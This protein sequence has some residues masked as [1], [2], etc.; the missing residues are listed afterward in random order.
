MAPWQTKTTYRGDN[1]NTKYIA[2][3]HSMTGETWWQPMVDQSPQFTAK[4][5]QMDFMYPKTNSTKTKFII[6]PA[7]HNAVQTMLR[8]ILETQRVDQPTVNKMT[9]HGLRLWAAEMAYRTEVPRDLRRYIGHWSEE[10]T[11][12]TYTREHAIIVNKIWNHIWTNYTADSKTDHDTLPVEPGDDYYLEGINGYDLSSIKIHQDR[13][14]RCQPKA[15]VDTTD[16]GEPTQ[17][18]NEGQSTPPQR[19][20]DGPPGATAQAPGLGP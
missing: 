17:Q 1:I 19:G 3:K 2:T 6:Q 12:D 13:H 18:D 20:N 14:T 4:F 5:P 7:S 15:P 16:L 10:K 11:A 9:L 8:H